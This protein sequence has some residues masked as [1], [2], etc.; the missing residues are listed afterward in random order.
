MSSNEIAKTEGNMNELFDEYT[1]VMTEDIELPIV[2]VP[3][4]IEEAKE[5]GEPFNDTITL[6]DDLDN[7][8]T[9]PGGFHIAEDSG[10]KLE[11]GIVIEDDAGNQ[12][13]WIPVGSYKTDS[14]EKINNLSRR[15]FTETS[16]KE[17]GENEPIQE[18]GREYYGEENNNSIAKNQIETFKQKTIE[19]GGFYIGRFEAGTNVE[20]NQNDRTVLPVIQRNKYAYNYI[21]RYE[22]KEQSDL[23]YLVNSFFTSELISSYAWD[24]A[25][26]FICQNNKEGYGLAVNTNT[27]YGNI[28]TEKIELTGNYANDKY[29]NIF[30]FAGNLIEY[31]T[32]YYIITDRPAVIRGASA[33]TTTYIADRG[34]GGIARDVYA[35]FRIQLYIK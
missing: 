3:T 35:G 20:R 12:F 2:E 23:L 6:K 25:L 14:G 24:T 33:M 34:N 22:Y 8:V 13:V 21:T 11:E 17:I 28:G 15:A 30:D 10:T 16:S 4:T 29:C 31:T 27:S 19:N 5:S 18:D 26:N 9:V 1:N 32:E 7:E